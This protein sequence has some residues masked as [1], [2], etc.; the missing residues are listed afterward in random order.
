MSKNKLLLTLHLLLPLVGQA[1]DNAV[2]ETAERYARQQTQGLPGEISIS[3]GQLGPGSLLPPCDRH[4]GYTPAGSR[5]WGKTNIGVRCLGPNTWSVLVPVQIR[6]TGPYVT[7]ARPLSAGQTIQ[8]GD[9]AKVTGD[10]TSLPGGV[11]I[12]PGSAIGKT[13]KNALAANTPLR[14]DQLLAPMVIRQGQTV[15][16]ISKGSGFAVSSEGK[17]INNA[18]EGQ[19]VQLRMATGQTVS[20]IARADGT[21][22]ISY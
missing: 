3:V 15:R 6:V 8:I 22:E 7:T 17:A 21:A 10:L 19:I 5:L 2:L 11:V 16:V 12:E 14:N 18:T 13:L 1:A 4:E 20:G 9:L